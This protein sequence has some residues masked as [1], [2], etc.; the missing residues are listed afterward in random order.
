MVPA[1]FAAAVMA[2][3]PMMTV[4]R[5][6]AGDPD[7]F[8]FTLPVT[9]AMTVIWPITQFDSDSLRLDGA[10]ESEAGSGNRCEQQ[11]FL[12]HISDSDSGEEKTGRAKK[13]ENSK[14]GTSVTTSVR[15]L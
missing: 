1:V 10:P 12:I 14:R 2:V 6:M 8:V 15:G 9:R 13:S 4:V 11:C 5:P 7:H 3:N